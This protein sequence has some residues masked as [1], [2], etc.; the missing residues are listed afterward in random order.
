M[1]KSLFTEEYRIFLSHLRAA[2]RSAHLTQGELAKLVGQSQ[3]F[4]SKCER[5][6]R[7]IDVVELRHLCDG[8][9][10]S[11]VDFVRTT[12]Y[13][14]RSTGRSFSAGSAIPRFLRSAAL[15]LGEDPS[16]RVQERFCAMKNKT[17]LTRPGSAGHPLPSERAKIL[18]DSR[19]SPGPALRDTLF[20]WR[21]PRF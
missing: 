14:C 6:E 16:R 4:V 18:I 8:L 20:P 9:G 15:S 11:L 10:I 13:E 19:P 7:R 12:N 1:T 3:S 5:G 17:P 2:R 21:G